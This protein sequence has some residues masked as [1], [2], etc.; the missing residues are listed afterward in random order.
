MTT[1]IQI[2]INVLSILLSAYLAYYFTK[3][4]YTFEKL[5]DKKLNCLEEIYG[6][7]ISL[8]KDLKKYVFTTGA[9]LNKE[10]LLK[11]REEISP[12]QDK[13]FQLQ[14]FFWNKEIILDESSVLAIQSFIDTSIEVLSKLKVSI[15]SQ[16]N[17]DA[18][19]SYEMWDNAFKAIEEKLAKAK[20][21][22]KEDFR[23]KIKN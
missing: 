3:Q 4:R 10:S 7:V 18:N 1:E 15:I 19:T 5:Y 16:G 11:K 22:L 21:L 9:E 8:E 2:I 6:K 13:F 14:E 17:N 23:K 20:S 12:I